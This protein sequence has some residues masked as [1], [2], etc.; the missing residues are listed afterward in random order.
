MGLINKSEDFSGWYNDVVKKAK[1]SDYSSVKGC[2]TILPYGYSLWEMIQGELNKKIKLLGASNMAFPM[3][4][5]Y[6]YFS[7]EQEHVEGFV[8]EVALVTSAGGKKLEEPLVVRPTSEVVIHEYFK[9][10][11]CSWRDLPLKVNQWCSVVR[12]EKRPRPFIRTTEFW[13]QEGHTA[14]ATLAEAQSQVL[15]AIF[16]YRDFCHNFLAIPVMVGKKPNIERFAGADE[17]FTIEGMM[18]DGKAVQMGTSHLLGAGFAKSIDMN[19]QNVEM[20]NCLPCLTSWGVTT[21]LIG[22]LIMVHG[23]QKGLVIPPFIAPILIYIVP[24]WR[25]KEEYQVVYDFVIKFTSYLSFYKI[26][27]FVDWRDYVTPGVK[28]QDAELQ[29]YPLRFDVGVRDLKSNNLSF[30]C[31]DTGDREVF[32][33]SLF[34]EN[35]D[36]AGSIFIESLQRKIHDRMYRKA[37]LSRKNN[38]HVLPDIKKLSLNASSQNVFYLS[39]WCEDD[40]EEIKSLQLT[41]R[42]LLPDEYDLKENLGLENC[43][44]SSLWCCV[45]GKSCKNEIKLV[46]IAKCY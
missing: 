34:S 26:T 16:M 19:F 6:S 24:I 33:F 20:S 2:M 30:V 41:V 23:D 45:H 28:F 17:T 31:R 13:W 10:K 25:N 27:F 15:D 35:S 44:I 5:P 18:G 8:P 36:K 4:I 32:H 43:D 1:L 46:I 14:H 9:D 11:I 42:C 40:Y 38:I 29:G 37:F 22:S 21:R 12:W 7:R 39:K 3:L